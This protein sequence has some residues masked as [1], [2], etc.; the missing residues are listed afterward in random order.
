MVSSRIRYALA[1]DRGV[2]GKRLASME[3][4]LTT[5]RLA[6]LCSLLRGLGFADDSS[7]FF[8]R[9]TPTAVDYQSRLLL[10]A[11]QMVCYGAS[12]TR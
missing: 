10:P 2:N 1:I 7:G 6:C 4:R 11:I 8:E 9:I 12:R 3:K 5:Q